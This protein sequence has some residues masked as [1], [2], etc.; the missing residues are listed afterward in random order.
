[1]G[2]PMAV[3]STVSTRGAL[4]YQGA[5]DGHAG[6]GNG[7]VDSSVINNQEERSNNPVLSRL[8]LII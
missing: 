6:G 5:G 2:L 1:M 8:L 4:T 3:S 7:L